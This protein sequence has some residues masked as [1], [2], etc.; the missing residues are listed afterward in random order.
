MVSVSGGRASFFVIT[1]T[2]PYDD[3]CPVWPELAPCRYAITP[4]PARAT[5]ATLRGFLSATVPTYLL[6][7]YLLPQMDGFTMLV[8]VLLPVIVRSCGRHA[9]SGFRHGSKQHNAV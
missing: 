7:F 5:Q 4:D 3:C 1:T 2:W 9:A 6:T 8:L